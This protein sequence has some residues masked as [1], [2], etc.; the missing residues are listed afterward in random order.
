MNPLCPVRHRTRNAVPVRA[1]HAEAN[2]PHPGTATV[3]AGEVTILG[4]EDFGQDRQSVVVRG[5]A[6]RR[7]L[8][9]GA[10]RGA[11]HVPHP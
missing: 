11:H 10:E 5:R 4:S 3:T 6:R 9:R 7:R 2:C 1:C 8:D